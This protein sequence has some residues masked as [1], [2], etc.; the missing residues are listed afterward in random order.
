MLPREL[1]SIDKTGHEDDWIPPEVL[2]TRISPDNGYCDS[3]F[4]PRELHQPLTLQSLWTCK[5]YFNAREDC[6]LF[7]YCV[8][9]DYFLWLSH[10]TY[11]F[12]IS[13]FIQLV[14]RKTLKIRRTWP[15]RGIF[16][17][18]FFSRTPLTCS[19]ISRDETLGGWV[20]RNC[21]L[22]PGW[23]KQKSLL[24]IF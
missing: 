23:C 13:C 6:N 7:T 19:T 21:S 8:Y 16:K 9:G 3:I 2:I 20:M 22:K 10:R 15:N 12:P 18:L 17:N 1:T 11:L 14:D 4:A 24:C 5:I